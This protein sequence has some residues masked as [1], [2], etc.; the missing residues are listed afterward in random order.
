MAFEGMQ[1]F[2]NVEIAGQTLRLK[3]LTWMDLADFE[4]YLIG[5]NAAR[6][7]SAISRAVTPNEIDTIRDATARV[8]RQSTDFYALTHAAAKTMTGAIWSL[9]RAA[10]NAGVNFDFSVIPATDHLDQINAATEAV[11]PAWKKTFRPEE[12]KT[13]DSP[14]SLNSKED[15]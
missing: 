15:Q 9:S 5:L 13:S 7:A 11:L 14:D 1:E 6:C 4:G 12:K 3:T 8:L 10:R 2:V